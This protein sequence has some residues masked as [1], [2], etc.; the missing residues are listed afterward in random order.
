MEKCWANIIGNCSDKLSREHL[1]SESVFKNNEIE[2]SGFE[3]CR[4]KPKAVGLSSL[5]SKILCQKHNSDLSILDSEAANTFK[6]IREFSR[7]TNVRRNLKNKNLNVLEYEINGSRLE[8]WFLK[9]LINLSLK[10]D[11]PIGVTSDRSGLPSKKLVEIVYGLK[12]FKRKAGLYF[13]VKKGQNINTKERIE[14]APLIQSNKYIEGGLFK[15][16]GFNFLI[17]LN[18][19]GPPDALT[20]IS[21][22]D[23]YW[24]DSLLN[25]HNKIIFDSISGKTS[26]KLIFNWDSRL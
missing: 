15:I 17:Y 6:K 25:F 10:S 13:V 9:T 20:G 16:K 8:R 11:L 2:V 26:Q 24:G 4:D 5:T 12:L 22:G 23:D 1:I 18:E 3:W 21:L 14:F 7:I 19:S